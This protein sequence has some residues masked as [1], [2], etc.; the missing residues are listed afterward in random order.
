[1]STNFGIVNL[2]GLPRN[3][4]SY[5]SKRVLLSL[6]TRFSHA[7][8]IAEDLVRPVPPN[9]FSSPYIT[10]IARKPEGLDSPEMMG[11]EI[12]AEK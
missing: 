6:L 5:L 9:R 10:C 2:N 11:K 8:W 12:L 1:M 3:S 7:V 4:V